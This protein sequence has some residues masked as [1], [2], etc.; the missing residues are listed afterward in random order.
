MGNF[1]TNCG[2][3]LEEG[4][5]CNCTQTTET[6][7]APETPEAASQP[8]PQPVAPSQSATELKSGFQNLLTAIKTIFKN[9][10]ETANTLGKEENWLTAIILIA[11]QAVLSGLFALATT[12][13]S[14]AILSFRAGDLAVVFFFTFICSLLLSAA[15]F[16]LYLGLG[17]AV[18]GQST[19]KS[20]LAVIGT[21]CFFTA[22]LTVI[23]ILLTMLNVVLGIIFFTAG[24]FFALLLIFMTIQKSFAI[25]ANKAFLIV[26]LTAV[27]IF[28][29]FIIMFFVYCNFNM[30][31]LLFGGFS[32][33]FG[34]GFSS[35]Y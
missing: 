33:S 2:R 28:I 20:A 22:P 18:K 17:K 16:G 5:V 13:I 19:P 26:G 12:G 11:A 24:E 34:S 3:P 32:S 14:L 7:P 15:M 21:R 8:Q 25:S 4:E 10:E 30:A 1:C 9:P 23:A 35:Y 6:Q 31:D 27:I 29:V